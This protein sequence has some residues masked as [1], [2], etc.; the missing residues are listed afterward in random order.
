M[1]SISL[2][3]IPGDGARTI[4]ISDTTTL[5]EVVSSQ[6]LFDRQLMVNGDAISPEDYAHY[7]LQDAVEIFATAAVKG[8]Q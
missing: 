8:N 5:A 2:V 4:Q 7:T 3:V 6:N 1:R